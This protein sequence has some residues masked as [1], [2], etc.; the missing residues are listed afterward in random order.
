MTISETYKE[1]L[2]DFEFMSVE[3]T[4]RPQPSGTGRSKKK[5]LNHNELERK[6]RL[7]QRNV[8]YELRDVIPSLQLVKPS[9]VLIMQKARDYIELLRNTIIGMENEIAQLRTLLM[10][11][12][13]HLPPPPM[14][15]PGGMASYAAA[16]AVSVASVMGNSNGGGGRS[17]SSGDYNSLQPLQQG[18]TH[19]LEQPPAILPL[20]TVPHL[21]NPSTPLNIGSTL[22]SATQS[23]PLDEASF[24]GHQDITQATNP[25][26]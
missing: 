14:L 2:E 26:A 24:S 12:G 7:H 17:S 11:S 13:Y 20:G 15:N 5:R 22:M 10:N 4:S 3:E 1:S 18:A 21:T 8:L 6:R 25:F 19:R 23:S 16:N 9:T